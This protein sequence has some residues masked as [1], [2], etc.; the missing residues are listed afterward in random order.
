MIYLSLKRKNI[1]EEYF[2]EII[3]IS[4]LKSKY[5]WLWHLLGFKPLNNRHLKTIEKVFENRNAFVHYKW[6]VFKQKEIEILIEQ[7][8]NLMSISAS[9]DKTIV[10]L[11]NY[12]NRH[13]YK[14]HKRI[15]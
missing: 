11:N 12:E 13:I 9:I 4:P 14:G 6:K 1:N 3:R 2:R 10:Y 5:T 15:F 7:I 8:N